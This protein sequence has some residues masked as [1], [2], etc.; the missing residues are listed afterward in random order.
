MP[1]LLLDDVMSE[2]DAKRREYLLQ[3]VEG[4]Q[5]LITTTERDTIKGSRGN[6]NYIEIR[7]GTRV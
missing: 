3:S 5:V 1:V 4:M 7:D 6:I 2:L